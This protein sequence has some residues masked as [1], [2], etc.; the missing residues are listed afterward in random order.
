M[1][2]DTIKKEVDR[3]SKLPAKSEKSN[4][5]SADFRILIAKFTSG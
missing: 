5:N 1:L 4:K 3:L 2:E